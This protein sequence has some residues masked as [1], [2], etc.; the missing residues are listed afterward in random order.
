MYHGHDRKKT[1]HCEICG[2]AF[3]DN[4]NL[5][6]HIHTVHEGKNDFPCSICGKAWLNKYTQIKHEKFCNV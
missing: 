5:K 1:F 6:L 2:K 3:T 4:R